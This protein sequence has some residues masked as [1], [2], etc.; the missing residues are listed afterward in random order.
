MNPS[1]SRGI[2]EKAF[3]SLSGLIIKLVSK[4]PNFKINLVTVL[5]AYH[6]DLSNSVYTAKPISQ[7][8]K[9]KLNSVWLYELV[10]TENINIKSI[11]SLCSD[12]KST[13]KITFNPQPDQL[14]NYIEENISSMFGSTINCGLLD[15]ESNKNKV[16]C[17][18][19]DCMALT[20]DFYENEFVGF[21]FC[22][23]PTKEF[24]ERLK[25][26]MKTQFY[27]K[28]YLKPKISFSKIIPRIYMNSKMFTGIQYRG[29]AIDELIGGMKMEAGGYISDYLNG[30][31]LKNNVDAPSIEV[32]ETNEDELREK[33]KTFRDELSI[34]KIN[35]NE[36]GSF[37][38]K[39]GSMTVNWSQFNEEDKTL[40]MIVNYGY[41]DEQP[42][43]GELGNFI[44][45]VIPRWILRILLLEKTRLLNEIKNKILK[46]RGVKFR[47]ALFD[48]EREVL[49]EGAI[50]KRAI[51]AF[52]KNIFDFKVVLEKYGRETA[53]KKNKMSFYTTFFFEL[54]YLRNRYLE[55]QKSL[56][57]YSGDV[58]NIFSTETNL[59]LQN[60][61]WYLTLVVLLISILQLFNDSSHA[62]LRKL[63][64]CI[65][66][67]LVA[68]FNY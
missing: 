48:I 13:K 5:K 43:A 25:E 63:F 1:R 39:N 61:V 55:K 42:L 59:K 66:D 24:H 21:K 28:I 3:F 34:L 17:K 27:P 45:I 67:L 54:E 33:G 60:K 47:Q 23:Y 50:C 37:Q 49:I 56:K 44:H 32:W 65:A 11:I 46:R 51:N 68:K 12:F 30:L 18:W 26:I 4:L 57:E 8:L 36:I 35:K 53:D 22:V 10:P 38:N 31:I 64:K 41:K 14:R 40:R 2:K 19:I 15:F 9:I 29:N 20:I 58:T 7:E 52:L 6:S 62:F 16:T